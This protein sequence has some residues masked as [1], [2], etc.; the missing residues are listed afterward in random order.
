MAGKI[1]EMIDF[2]IE[3]RSRN[4]TTI[5]SIV[6]TKMMLKGVNPYKYNHLSDDDPNIIGKLEKMI[7]E[8]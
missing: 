1:K 7:I 4:N 3:Q 8:S 2:I 6:K 5:E